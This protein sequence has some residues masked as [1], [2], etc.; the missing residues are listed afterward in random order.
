MKLTG[1]MKYLVRIQRKNDQFNV[2][3]IV[4]CFFCKY[5]RRGNTAL[6]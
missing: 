3:E 5:I 2:C 4:N 6:A 1:K